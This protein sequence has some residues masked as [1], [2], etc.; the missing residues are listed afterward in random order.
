MYT[1]GLL[2]ILHWVNAI[3]Y[4]IWTIR[5]F[6]TKSGHKSVAVQALWEILDPP[7]EISQRFKIEQVKV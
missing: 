3:L 4:L 6:W 1:W 7:L 2:S 5:H